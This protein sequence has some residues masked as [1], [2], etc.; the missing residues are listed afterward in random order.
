MS[1]SIRWKLILSISIP[2][3]LVGGEASKP[4]NRI[5]Y[6]LNPSR[7]ADLPEAEG[8]L[9]RDAEEHPRMV[10]QK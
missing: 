4:G 3:L 7:R 9:L 8:G 10:G 5:V 6:P 2:L 1:L